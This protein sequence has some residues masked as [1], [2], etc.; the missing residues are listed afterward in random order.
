MLMPVLLGGCVSDAASGAPAVLD[1]EEETADLISIGFSQL[2]AES[3][4]RSANTQSMLE[5]FTEEYGYSMIYENGQQKHNTACHSECH[6]G[7]QF[8]YLLY[9]R[10]SPARREKTTC[11][12]SRL[13]EVPDI[14]ILT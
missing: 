9:H 4:W 1:A 3:D 6:A 2:G 8:F 10:L 11:S 5:S 12:R 13:P 7:T 14:Y